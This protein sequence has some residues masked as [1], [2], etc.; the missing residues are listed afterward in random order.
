MPIENQCLEKS[1]FINKKSKKADKIYNKTNKKLQKLKVNFL[2]IQ[3]KNF[4]NKIKV[5]NRKI[6]SEKIGDETI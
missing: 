4:S 3:K 6:K 1:A 2:N 5:Y